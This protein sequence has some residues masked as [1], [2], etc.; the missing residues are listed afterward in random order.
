MPNIYF[1]IIND[2]NTNIPALD[3]WTYYFDVKKMTNASIE[4]WRYAGFFDSF[5]TKKGRFLQSE[6]YLLQIREKI[7]EIIS[8]KRIDLIVFEQTG[9]L[10]WPW[11]QYF[12]DGV[13]CILRI[14][15]SHYLYFLS[16]IKTR[17]KISSK[18]SSMGSAISQKR[19]ER[20][21]IRNWD[22]IQFL[23]Q[24]EYQTYISEYPDLST[25]FS[26]TPPS[27]I[28]HNNE[29][30]LNSNKNFDA[31]F[32]GTMSWKPNT[33]AI[34]WFLNEVLP[35]IKVDLP[36]FKVKIVGKD[37]AQKIKSDNEN[38]EVIGYV[39]SLD[40]FYKTTRISI[41]PARSGGGVKVKLMEA[42]AFGLPII[43]TNH[44]IAG[45]NED[46]KNN[47]IVK[48]KPEDFATAVIQLLRNG[49]LR[50]EY[51]C[52]IFGYAQRDFDYKENQKKW[53]EEVEKVL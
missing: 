38:V 12:S 23:S 27:I 26:Y 1:C 24:K 41:N 45:F 32:V 33:D 51:S 19:Y 7:Q 37:A 13:R 48:N 3:N 31:L 16:D 9:I 40:D 30:L 17:R 10:M 52:K 50:K 53:K 46:I 49:E 39:E 25:K 21:Y 18:I 15:D 2:E 36:N 42:A 11:R 43:T 4:S 29:Y 47:L 5:S 14:H 22:Q 28:F 6:K 20:K 44:G 8:E 35:L 34:N